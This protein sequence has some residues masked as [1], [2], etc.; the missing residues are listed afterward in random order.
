M[1]FIQP[2]MQMQYWIA[3]TA[4]MRNIPAGLPYLLTQLTGTHDG[5]GGRGE[6]LRCIHN[7]AFRKSNFTP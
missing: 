7:D 6:A 1:S 4:Y 2:Q 3:L 5:P